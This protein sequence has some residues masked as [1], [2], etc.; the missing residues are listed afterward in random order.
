MMQVFNMPGS[1]IE[2]S[3]IGNSDC[4][5][6]SG[7]RSDLEHLMRSLDKWLDEAD[8]SKSGYAQVSK[9][10]RVLQ[11]KGLE[12]ARSFFA[13]NLESLSM[14]LAGTALWELLKGTFGNGLF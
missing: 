3:P 12:A 1:R 2:G 9:L 6:V 4:V 14:S 5:F 7:E 10:Q 8:C 11:S 13:R